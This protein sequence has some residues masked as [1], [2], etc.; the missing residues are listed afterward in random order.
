VCCSVTAAGH[1]IAGRLPFE[2]SSSDLVGTVARMWDEVDGLVLV[3][4]AGIAVRAIAPHLRSKSSDPAVVCVDDAGQFALCL[5]GG[6]GAGGNVLAADVAALVGAVPVV[7]TATDARSIPA[8]DALPGFRCEGDVSGVTRAWLDGSPPGAGRDA[9]VESWPL[10]PGLSTEPPG[11]STE[12]AGPGRVTAA[13]GRVTVSD[14]ARRPGENEVLLRPPSLVVG[15]GASSGASTAGLAELA[16]ELLARAGLTTLS[17][18]AVATLDRKRC[19][20]AVASLAGE[21]AVPL[22][23]FTA[24][25]LAGV[26]VP[27]PSEAVL[28]AV[29]TPSVSEAAAL[30]A[31]GPGAQLVCAKSVTADRD[32]TVAVARRLRPTG[33][34]AVVG[35][36]PGEPAKRT[37]EAVAAVRTADVVVGFDG[38]VELASD[39]IGPHHEVHRRPIGEE[40]ERCSYAL[41][42]AA[43]GSKVALL[44]SGDPGVYAMASLVMELAGR[45]GDPPVTVIPGVTAALSAS[46]VLGAP[47]GHDHASVSLSDLLTPWDVIERRLKAVAEGDFVVSLYNPRSARRVN[48][49]P[50]AIEILAGHRPAETPAAIVT[51][52]GRPGAEIVR[53]TLGDLDPDRV[54]MLSLVVVGS[55]TTRWIGE[56]MVTPRGYVEGPW[57]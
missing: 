34:L 49:L 39:L 29:G 10:P 44:C 35:L 14:L 9:G 36:G 24:G 32:A 19:E 18:G 31:A 2:H 26:E 22:L 53:A 5:I 20:P 51:A 16:R 12:P 28:D 50:R 55:T 47:L 1:E 27:N 48:Q 21:L 6:H 52:V 42:R 37:I 56:R 45:Y 38:Y 7:T 46:A 3:C 11:L 57:L 54:G 15:V 30:L 43:S 25:E 4:A 23:G 17:V 33:H 13:R 41:E 8:L 40:A